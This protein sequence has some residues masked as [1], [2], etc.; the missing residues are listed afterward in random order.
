MLLGGGRSRAV[1]SDGLAWL[2]SRTNL[3]MFEID[4]TK[5]YARMAAQ[6]HALQDQLE[7]AEA[8]P[9]LAELAR[10]RGRVRTAP[11]LKGEAG[12]RSRGSIPWYVPDGAEF[13]LHE[14][15]STRE[16]TLSSSHRA[17][18]TWER[19]DGYEYDELYRY[20]RLADQLYV[21]ERE[22]DWD[23]APCRGPARY[24]TS[25]LDIAYFRPR[26]QHFDEDE[27]CE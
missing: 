13:D 14:E 7:G 24:P 19:N 17:E 11:G 2:R 18:Q 8:R 3:S 16:F 21:D 5:L 25:E 26:R 15:R 9:H 12:Q 22:D 27:I 10:S 23:V 4:H 6:N 20:H 1:P